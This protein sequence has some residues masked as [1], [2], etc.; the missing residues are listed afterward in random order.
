MVTGL[1]ELDH[2]AQVLGRAQPVDGVL[3][4]LHEAREKVVEHI[5]VASQLLEGRAVVEGDGRRLVGPN[6]LAQPEQA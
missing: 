4:V 5:L 6:D 3:A 2:V 1:R